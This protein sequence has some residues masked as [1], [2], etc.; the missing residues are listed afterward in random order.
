MNRTAQLAA[1]GSGRE[2]GTMPAWEIAVCVALTA[3]GLTLSWLTLRRSGPRRAVR[4]AAWSLLPLAAYLTGALPLVGRIVSA[5]VRFAGSFVFSP[6]AWA[7]I[8]VL[9]LIVV[10]FLASGGLPARSRRKD[11]GK[12]QGQQ[13]VGTAQSGARPAVP[14]APDKARASGK[15]RKAAGPDQ[16]EDF[17]EVAEILRRRGIT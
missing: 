4:V 16:D 1:N 14:A 17:A 6:R 13:A 5:I 8:A 10:M 9:G 2:G 12:S 3:V 11:R 7:G 15:S